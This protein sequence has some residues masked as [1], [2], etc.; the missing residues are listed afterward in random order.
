[1][2][3]G[4]RRRVRDRAGDRCEYSHMPARLDPTPVQID[5]VIAK[6]HRGKSAFTNLAQICAL[7]NRYKGPNV[8]GV[9]PRTRQLSRLF[10]PRRDEW[11]KHFVWRS[12][13]L[14]GLTRIGRTTIAVLVING[15]RR[16]AARA[17]LIA[18]GL[19]GEFA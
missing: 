5:H 4:L 2:N 1:V 12:A 6:Q 13:T 8:A 11:R 3:R 19:G 18:E 7:C 17:A 14:L 10:D 15:P 9:D 16:V